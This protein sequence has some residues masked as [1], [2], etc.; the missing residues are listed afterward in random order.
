MNF[1]GVARKKL[2]REQN[3]A[4]S[5]GRKNIETAKNGKRSREDRGE[6]KFIALRAFFAGSAVKGFSVR[7]NEKGGNA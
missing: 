1:I 7:G 2:I 3:W 4:Q 6:R 5:P